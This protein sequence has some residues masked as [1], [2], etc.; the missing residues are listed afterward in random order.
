MGPF[1]PREDH[2]FRDVREHMADFKMWRKLSRLCRNRRR[3]NLHD[4]AVSEVEHGSTWDLS[5]TQAIKDVIDVVQ[6]M[7]FHLTAESPRRCECE[8]LS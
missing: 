5:L 2:N 7:G 4:K 8:R 3:E 1:R 6:R